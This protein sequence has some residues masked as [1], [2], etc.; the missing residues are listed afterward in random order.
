MKPHNKDD[1]YIDVHY[2]DKP[3]KMPKGDNMGYN[4]SK[5]TGYDSAKYNEMLYKKFFGKHGHGY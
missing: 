1:S 5:L 2:G 3:K 4:M